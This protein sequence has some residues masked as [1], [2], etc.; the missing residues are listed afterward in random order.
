MKKYKKKFLDEQ[1]TTLPKGS[2][3]CEL[4]CLGFNHF[5]YCKEMRGNDIQHYGVD[6]CKPDSIPEEFNFS[7]ADL[8]Q[9]QTPYEDDSFDLVIAE[10]VIEHIQD[11]L[12]FISEVIWICKPGGH[13]Y[14]EAPSER[15]LLLPGF[16]FKHEEFRS[17]SYWDDP[18]HLG[19]PWSPQ[20]F[21]R[22]TKLFGCT[23]VNVGYLY[24][25]KSRL[26]LPLK[27]MYCLVQ[28][29]TRLEGSVWDAI[30]WASGLIGQKPLE[31]IGKPNFHY[32]YPECRDH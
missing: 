1:Y 29:D 28:K 18:T 23:P 16:P 26:L 11:P 8:N 3:V 25:L 9:S 19:R 7:L 27:L 31:V 5:K 30:G 10:H 17:L 14:I 2:K 22:V 13:F 20:A 32:Y 21:F 15:A 4:G 24:S 6:Y 12:Q